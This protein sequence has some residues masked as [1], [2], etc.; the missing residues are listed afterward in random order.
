MQETP[1]NTEKTKIPAA[2]KVLAAV[3]G[4]GFVVYYYL[5]GND[6]YT[7][8]ASGVAMAA[9]TYLVLCFLYG[10]LL[11][12]PN[13][14]QKSEEA[15]ILERYIKE[16]EG[17][18]AQSQ[19]FSPPVSSPAP[20]SEPM[21]VQTAPMEKP[22]IDVSELKKKAEAAGPKRRGMS[23]VRIPG[24]YT[25]V[26]TETTGLDAEKDRLIEIAA[27]RVRSGKET[28]R[29]ETLINPGRKLTKKIVSLTGITDEDVKNAPSAEEALAAFLAFLKDDVIVAHNANFDVDF[30]FESLVRCGLPPIDN[31]FID[32][33]RIAKY[34][35]PDV[36]NYKLSTLAK[37]YNIPQSTAHRAL[38][39]CETTLALLRALDADA[40][41]QGIDFMQ[42]QKKAVVSK[43]KAREV[44]PC[45]GEGKPESPLYKKYCCFAGELNSMTRLEAMQAITDLGGF[46]RDKISG[47]TNYL[48]VGKNEYGEKTFNEKKAEEMIASGSEIRYVMESEL[49]EMFSS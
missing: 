24:H 33:L 35:D 28:A 1:N 41:Q 31:N 49:L 44:V 8:L 20:V 45:T 47:K 42:I 22:D 3:C 7:S 5:S 36:N 13:V 34:I 48:I 10:I 43:A 19:S 14:G 27:I 32:T 40:K 6:L 46:C 29:F 39:D 17:E 11:A 18:N 12:M 15:E 4:V 9:V 38:A 2:L 30:I 26:D 37:A 21:P 25:V 16:H 23:I